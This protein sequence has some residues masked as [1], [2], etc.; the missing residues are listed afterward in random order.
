[1]QIK[2]VENSKLILPILALSPWKAN[3]WF[4]T[5]AAL[6][7]PKKN[8]QTKYAHCDDHSAQEN[9]KRVSNLQR[10][11]GVERQSL[12][13]VEALG[14]PNICHSLEQSGFAYLQYSV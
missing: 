1:M 7:P 3:S 5:P 12:M 6:R 11:D 8:L 4:L 2:P 9:D 13:R 14:D 10:L